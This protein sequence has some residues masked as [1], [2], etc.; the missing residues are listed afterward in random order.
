MLSVIHPPVLVD[1]AGDQRP[2]PQQSR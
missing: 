1:A 2:T